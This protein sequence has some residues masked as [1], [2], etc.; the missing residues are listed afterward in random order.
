MILYL[1]I[2]TDI[3][4]GAAITTRYIMDKYKV[5]RST[6]RAALSVLSHIG[7]V[8]EIR[9][10]HTEGTVYSVSPDA[11]DK[12]QEYRKLVIIM[13]ENPNEVRR[14]N[15]ALLLSP[16]DM[17]ERGFVSAHNQLFTALAARRREMKQSSGVM[18]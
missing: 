9:R 8:T 3:P 16:A 13:R 2:A 12:A 14:K 7:A 4:A 18:A 1:K 10:V 11:E 5:S 15:G 6:S 17:A